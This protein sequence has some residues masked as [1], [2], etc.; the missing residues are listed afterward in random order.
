M[1]DLTKIA[2]VLDA[3]AAYIEHVEQEKQAQY[4]QTRN[5]RV[6]KI[7][8]AHEATYG[9]TLPADM[10]KKLAETDDAGL[11]VVEDLLTRKGGE[12]PSLGAGQ[13]NTKE[14]AFK[15]SKD[16]AGERFAR[17]ILT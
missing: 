13:A 8:A 10:Y 15:D 2:A 9:E 7:A 6:A 14:A 1:V 11:D 4:T 17:W 3:T 5:Q 16:P 12:L